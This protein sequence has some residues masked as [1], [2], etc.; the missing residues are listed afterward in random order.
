MET[1]LGGIED[2]EVPVWARPAVEQVNRML[3]AKRH[4]NFYSRP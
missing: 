3:G 4:D 2:G 1:L